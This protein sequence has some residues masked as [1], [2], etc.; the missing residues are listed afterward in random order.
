MHTKATKDKKDE[1]NFTD[2]GLGPMGQGMFEMMKK[3]CAGR[4]GFPDCSTGMEGMLEAM[5]KQH[6]CK[7]DKDAAEPERKKK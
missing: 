6:C 1:A 3:C 5:K 4:G 2:F 7:P